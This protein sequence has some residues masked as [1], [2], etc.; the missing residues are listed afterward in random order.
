LIGQTFSIPEEFDESGLGVE[1][2]RMSPKAQIEEAFEMFPGKLVIDKNY[3]P[4][5]E[6]LEGSGDPYFFDMNNSDW[7]LVRILHRQLHSDS[8]SRRTPLP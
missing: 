8:S 3:L 7:H 6:C 4:V 1:M 2:E 5:G